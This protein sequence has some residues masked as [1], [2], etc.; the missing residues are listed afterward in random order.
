MA[1]NTG[2]ELLMDLALIDF[3]LEAGLAAEV[4]LY[5]KPQPFFV[6]D[7]MVADVLAGLDA[8]RGGVKPLARWL[9]VRKTPCCA[10]IWHSSSIGSAQPASST[11]SCRSI[12]RPNWWAWIW[13]SSRGM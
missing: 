12:C 10:M 11:I 1:D 3:L 2:T 8:L 13:L 4:R 5:L 9:T 7:A 6:S